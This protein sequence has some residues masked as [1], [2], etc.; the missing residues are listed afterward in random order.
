M[1]FR[2][3]VLNLSSP[4]AVDGF[5]QEYPT[6]VIFKAGTCHKT[7]QGFGFVQEKL[8]TREDLMVGI[9]RVVEARPA[10]D[11]I[12]N[13]TGIIHHSPQV[14]LFKDGEA[15]FDVD[16]WDITPEVLDQG[17][18]HTPN[19]GETVESGEATSS[20]LG[21]YKRMIEQYLNGDLTDQ[22]F[23]HIYTMTFRDDASLRTREEVEVLGR[24]C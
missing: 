14:I 16:N 1:A 4:E 11:L 19:S 2:D 6:S 18:S 5:L 9:I 15:V 10:S 21:V 7:M 23:E 13:K 20:D 8:E 3:R 17:L 22:Q 12:T 24:T